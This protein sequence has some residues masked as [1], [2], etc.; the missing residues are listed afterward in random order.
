MLSYLSCYQKFLPNLT[1]GLPT[2]LKAIRTVLQLGGLFGGSNLW[3]VDI[4]TK[5]HSLSLVT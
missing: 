2:L 4:K 1:V 5:Y 3:Q